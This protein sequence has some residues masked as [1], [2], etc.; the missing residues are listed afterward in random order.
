MHARIL[1]AA[2]WVVA[3]DRS[4]PDAGRSRTGPVV[5]PPGFFHLPHPTQATTLFLQPD[6][7]ARLWNEECDSTGLAELTWRSTSPATVELMNG[8][9]TYLATFQDGGTALVNPPLYPQ[10]G[11]SPEL[12]KPGA[13]CSVCQPGQP[14]AVVGCATPDA[15]LVSMCCAGGCGGGTPVEQACRFGSGLRA[16]EAST[17]NAIPAG[18][19]TCPSGSVHAAECGAYPGVF[20]GG[21]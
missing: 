1:V 18:Q 9:T 3:C 15:G 14:L 16:G 12:W 5:S 21:G 13:V 6:G 17:G 10:R 11:V 4:G 8:T 19:C 7:V 2:L 20:C